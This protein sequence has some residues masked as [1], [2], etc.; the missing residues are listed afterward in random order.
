LPKSDQNKTKLSYHLA[1]DIYMNIKN[2]VFPLES[3]LPAE[4]RLVSKYNVGRNTVREALHLL[5]IGGF[6][7]TLHGSGSQVISSIG[8]LLNPIFEDEIVSKQQLL[9]DLY[10]YRKVIEVEAAGKAAIRR[11]DEDLKKMRENLVRLEATI[12]KGENF[13]E[14]G[15]AYHKLIS[16]SSNSGFAINLLQNIQNQIMEV[17]DR[18][19]ITLYAAEETITFHKNLYSAMA[20]GSSEKARKAMTADMENAR[21]Q[22]VW[23]INHEPKIML[24]EPWGTLHKLA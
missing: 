16:A 19:A 20:S 24:I 14:C 21:D 8:N 15:F 18:L 12:E 13:A 11:T 1:L 2:G 5:N 9:L 23:A 22:L 10:D 4:N 7:H 17:M 6:I 3:W